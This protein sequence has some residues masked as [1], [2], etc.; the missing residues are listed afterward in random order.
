MKLLKMIVLTIT[1]VLLGACAGRVRYDKSAKTAD[2]IIVN[3]GS[4]QGLISGSK[5][6][7]LQQDC[8]PNGKIRGCRYNT[9]G[10]LTVKQVLDKD[11]SLATM[12]GS[13]ELTETTVF[14]KAN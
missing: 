8:T 12:D 6:V 13:F 7:A 10:F 2:G 14:E 4:S 11:K 5:I 3:L 1:V 9:K